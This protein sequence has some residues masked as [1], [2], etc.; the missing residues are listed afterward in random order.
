VTVNRGGSWPA[1]PGLVD[2]FDTAALVVGRSGVVVHANEV[3]QRLFAPPGGALE[4]AGLLATLFEDDE[5]VAMADAVDQVLAGSPWEG[6]LELTRADGARRTADV[7]CRP[8]WQDEDVLGLVCVVDDSGSDPDTLRGARR[9]G[10]SLTRLARVTAELVMADTVEAV[11]KIVTSHTA[12]AMGATIA[13]LTLRDGEDMLRL[14]GLRGGREGDAQQWARYSVNTRTPASDVVRSGE[15]LVLTGAAAIAERY[16]ELPSADRGQ[17]S[18]VSLPLRVTARTIGAIG[19]S[20]PGVRMLDS[21]ELEFLEVM[22][23]T[24]AQALDRI[25]A[26]EVATKQTTRLAFLA[27]A[28]IELASSLD[29]ETTLA[30]VA[31]LAVPTF[32]DWCAI[33][34]VRDGRL[35]RV[36]VAHVDPEKVEHALELQRRYPPDPNAPT[37]PWNVVR[38]GQAELIAEITD[39]MLV[40]AAVDEEQ[41]RIARELHLRSAL[42]VPLKARGRVVGVISWV[43]SESERLYGPDDV[44]F[45][46]HLARRAATA[47]DNAEL[48]SQTLAA[49]DQL[50]RAVL[51]ETLPSAAGWQVSHYYSPSGRTEVCG[52]FYDAVALGD[53][54][55]VLFVGDVMGRGVAAAAAMAQVRA[56]VRAY[57]VVDPT[58]EVVM[59][60]LDLMFAQYGRDQLVTLVYMVANPERDELLVANAGHP[61][62]LILRRDLGIEQLPLAGGPPLGAAAGR[63]GQ[64]TVRLSPGDTL[65]AF[66]D[67]LVERRDEDI[68]QGLERLQRSLPTLDQPDLSA[69][70]ARL[71]EGTRDPSQDDDVAALVARR[72]V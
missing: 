43:T 64:S 34:V 46:E 50:Q 9:L 40:A 36:A 24:C 57:T 13:S 29:Y 32:A 30:R 1:D 5:Q 51:P 26:S 45:A 8:L 53:G 58:P 67:G 71:V 12:D 44:S 41:L 72:V 4:G 63:R 10:D 65:L 70:L 27:H 37:G 49:A 52:D 33:D 60:K 14:A 62:P 35:N 47:I 25:S 18:I 66:T 11:T 31:R 55:L 23:D 15:R 38:T 48:H 69:A 54:R 2:A 6:R 42:T 17:R 59:R 16:P 61:P 21:A 56:A 20:F 19:L 7:R 3:A 22:A 28:S 39:E 68:D